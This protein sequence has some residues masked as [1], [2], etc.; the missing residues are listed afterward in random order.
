MTKVTYY[1]CSCDT[2][3]MSRERMKWMAEIVP[4]VKI[5]KKGDM[6]GIFELLMR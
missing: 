2:Y 4:S 1:M 6:M 3:C 5:V